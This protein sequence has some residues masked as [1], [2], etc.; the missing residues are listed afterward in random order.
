MTDRFNIEHI[1]RLARISLAAHEKSIFEKE[2]SEILSYFDKVDSFQ[3]PDF[4]DFIALGKVDLRK[5]LVKDSFDDENV[6]QKGIE[7]EGGYFKGPKV[8]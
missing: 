6:V 3:V 5:D 2:F 1:A 8:L 4:E 7:M